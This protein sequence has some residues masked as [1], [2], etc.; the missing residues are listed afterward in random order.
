MARGYFHGQKG[1][2]KAFDILNFPLSV[3]PEQPTAKAVGH[4]WVK[5]TADEAAQITHVVMDDAIRLNYTDGYLIF[6]LPD[7]GAG[8]E[9]ITQPKKTTSGGK[10]PFA[11]LHQPETIPEWQTGYTE[12]IAD[13]KYPWPSVKYRLGG[14]LKPA[15]AFAWDGVQ[16]VQFSFVEAFLFIA[17]NASPYIAMYDVANYP[18]TRGLIDSAPD[19]TPD[20]IAVSSDKKYVIPIFNSGSTSAA[21]YT[22]TC[23]HPVEN[24][25]SQLFKQKLS[26]NTSAE[27]RSVGFLYDSHVLVVC[28][29]GS[30]SGSSFYLRFYQ[31]TDSGVTAIANRSFS[32]SNSDGAKRMCPSPVDPYIAVTV[33]NGVRIYSYDDNFN[34][35][36]LYKDDSSSTIGGTTNTTREVGFSPDG[37][38]VFAFTGY[39]GETLKI[40]K[41]SAGTVTLLFT[42]TGFD[43]G[44]HYAAFT[45]DNQYLVTW[46][47]GLSIQVWTF[48]EAGLSLSDTDNQIGFFGRLCM[49]NDVLFIATSSK[50]IYAKKV[51]NGHLISD[52]GYNGLLS[53]VV[54]EGT[55]KE[56]DIYPRV[57]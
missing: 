49:V 31:I 43:S 45:K 21:N 7:A 33:R 14:S 2:G 11:F 24:G 20:A 47:G 3:Q 15:E 51:E 56:A 26:L 48:S 55:A 42:K 57:L 46:G 22:F 16:W 19:D 13:I 1:G 28:S 50:T 9:S 40:L 36:Q 27:I 41:I 32:A 4:V 12:E 38:Y 10:L 18:P 53:G 8:Y 29:S 30:S 23:F 25:L 17:M 44:Y 52:G 6:K 39:E 37:K 35:T 34:C 5:L 54:L